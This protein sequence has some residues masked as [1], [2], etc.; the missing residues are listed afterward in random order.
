[1]E[2]QKILEGKEVVVNP[3]FIGHEPIRIILSVPCN[4][5]TKET[6]VSQLAHIDGIILIL[7]WQGPIVHLLVFCEDEAAISRKIQLISS[8][9]GCDDPVILR[10]SEALGF[11]KCKLRANTKD[12]MILQSI[13]K[14]PRKRVQQIAREIHLSSRT[15]ERRIGV[16]TSDHAFFHMVRMGFENLDGLTCSIFVFYTNQAQKLVSDSE[17]SSR[18]QRL[19]FSA[20]NGTKISQ[21]TF[22]CKNVAEAENIL[23][24]VRTLDGIEKIMM[25][26][27]TKYILVTEWLDYEINA[28]LSRRHKTKC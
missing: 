1:M 26:F 23:H 22:V 19:V 14:N 28:E 16:L 9:C 6:L 3:Y 12:L 13:R 2:R 11:Y 20:T 27:V 25:G 21:F 8:I 17:I 24:W 10:N 5:K 7:D 15:V 4:E 18:L